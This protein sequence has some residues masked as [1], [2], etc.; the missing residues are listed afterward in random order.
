MII[1]SNDW[2]KMRVCTSSNISS[3]DPSATHN[4]RYARRRHHTWKR[5]RSHTNGPAREIASHEWK[6][7]GAINNYCDPVG[8]VCC[9]VLTI[10]PRHIVDEAAVNIGVATKIHG[11]GSGD[12]SRR[13]AAPAP[14]ARTSYKL[15][16]RGSFTDVL[17]LTAA[18]SLISASSAKN[19]PTRFN[20]PVMW[21]FDSV[22]VSHINVLD[23]PRGRTSISLFIATQE[24]N[25][26]C[27]LLTSTLVSIALFPKFLTACQNALLVGITFAI[28]YWCDK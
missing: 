7:S 16:H 21:K 11:G 9:V 2:C 25:I 8:S 27:L 18:T 4:W 6:R 28:K 10:R 12:G 26:F 14:T 20:T 17:Y 1:C 22:S 3:I 15:R 5:K 23:S 24:V 13:Q 19:Q